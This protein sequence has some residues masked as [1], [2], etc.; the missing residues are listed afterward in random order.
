MLLVL[1]EHHVKGSS[2][3]EFDAT[4]EDGVA[5]LAK[6]SGARLAWF[7]DVAHGAGSSYVAIGCGSPGVTEIRQLPE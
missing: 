2:A 4:F 3:P 7:F 5:L 1:E 6:S